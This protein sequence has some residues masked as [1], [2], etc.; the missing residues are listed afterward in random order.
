MKYL[1]V[2]ELRVVFIAI[3]ITL[4]P[5]LLIKEYWT[6]QPFT[7]S[8]HFTQLTICLS[9]FSIVG[10]WHMLKKNKCLDHF[11]GPPVCIAKLFPILLYYAVSPWQMPN[12]F[13]ENRVITH[14]WKYFSNQ[15]LIQQAQYFRAKHNSSTLG[16]NHR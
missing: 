1:E 12:S 6:T 10:T 13:A 5:L 16:R 4:V 11:L 15:V 8:T 2:L 14:E 9:L 3:F 7:K